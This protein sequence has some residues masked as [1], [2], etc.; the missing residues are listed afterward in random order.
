MSPLTPEIL[1][2]YVPFRVFS[3]SRLD[4]LL[5]F[6]SRLY[7]RKG[8]LLLEP[9]SVQ[10]NDYFLM[11]GE[12]KFEKSGEIVAADFPYSLHYKR[13]YQEVV[14]AVTDCSLFQVDRD[15]LDRFVCWAQVAS[16]LDLDIAYQRQYDDKAEWMR[17]LLQSNLFYKVSPLNLQKIFSYMSPI[18]MEQGQ[19]IIKQGEMG[20]CCYFIKKGTLKVT[21]MMA[22]E[23][24]AVTLAELGVGRCVG[25]DALLHETLRNATVTAISDG[26]LMKMDKRDFV[27][28]LRE[29]AVDTLMSSELDMVLQTGAI[30]LDV[31]TEEEYEYNHLVGAICMPIDLL[32]IK[33]RMLDPYKSYV[34]YCDTDRRSKAATYLLDQQGIRARAL[35]G[36][37]NT[38]PPDQKLALMLR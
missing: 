16:Y 18:E 36:G 10:G 17:T 7:V 38:L 11:S 13:Q 28:L 22:G 37:M 14:R 19:T 5:N 15:I 9:G 1:L 32:R 12:V 23:A 20:D 2:A 8:Q 29:P 33:S 6:C 27:Q 4:A 25:E 30:L 31:R 24:E 35:L 21:R 34:V 26:I 3:E